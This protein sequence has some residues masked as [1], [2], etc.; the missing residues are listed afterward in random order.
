MVR[1]SEEEFAD[2]VREA[3]RSLPDDFRRR[4][5]NI[6]VDIQPLADE[7]T[8]REMELDSP[9]QLLGLYRGVPLPDRHVEAPWMWPDRIV[10]Y[11]RAIE[12]ATRNRDEAVEQVRTTV[13]HEVGHFFGMDEDDLE[14][15][16]YG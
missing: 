6:A 4:M 2:L 3:I 11:Q 9:W 10:I 16:G 15:L 7:R 13:L 12:N 14:E 8:I 1:F 5:E